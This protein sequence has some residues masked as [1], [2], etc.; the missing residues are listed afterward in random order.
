MMADPDETPMAVVVLVVGPNEVPIATVD[1]TVRCDLALVEQILRLHLAVTR[2]GWSIR[3]TDVA[4]D[5]R[6]LFEF[7]GVAHRLGI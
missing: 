3:L 4:D 2:H 7:V 1:R 5:L 6:A